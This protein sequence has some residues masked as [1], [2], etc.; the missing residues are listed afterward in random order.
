MKK[1]FDK[2]I[3]SLFADFSAASE[4]NAGNLRKIL[5]DNQSTAY[6]KK[7]G[8][9]DIN[10]AKD[11]VARVPVSNYSNYEEQIC[12]G[13]EFLAYPIKYILGTS[14]TTGK[15]K[16]FPLTKEA[17]VRYSSYIYDMPYFLTHV[18]GKSL[19]TSVFRSPEKITLLSSAY[20]SYLEKSGALDGSDFV[21]GRELLFSDHISDVQYVKARLLLSHPE[22]VSIQ[23]IFVYDVLLILRYLE[24]NWQILID[25]M[26]KKRVSSASLDD[27]IKELMY[28][29]C[30][31][32]NRLSE[33]EE[34]FGRASGFSI[35][36]ILPNLRFISGI[37][38]KTYALQEA[39]LRRYV[40]DTPIYY[41]A[42]A[43][44]ECMMGVAR[45]MDQAEY[46]LLPRSAYYE[47][48]PLDGTK[49]VQLDEISVGESY[50]PV[51]TTFS[52]LYRYQT[53][54]II[55]ILSYE[56]E[57]PVFEVVGRRDRLLNVA[58]EKLDEQTLK[59]AVMRLADQSGTR[60][61]DFAIGVD[62][63]GVP[64]GYALF[65]EAE[66]SIDHG[67]VLFDSILRLLSF[68]YDDIRSLG[69]LSLPSVYVLGAGDI[70]RICAQ[71]KEPAHNKPHTFLDAQQVRELINSAKEC[72]T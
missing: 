30:A 60:I 49:P 23:S 24:S 20:F 10:S 48:L 31:E 34:I 32:E 61:F 37:G 56:G 68:D 44:S 47:F 29:H 1:S 51:I 38:G 5:A 66:R 54:D 41:F 45:G 35:T 28:R 62:D 19:H 9:S 63:R 6:G 71:V 18:E 42:Y 46:V 50:E 69:M 55:K 70:S 36:D 11:Y 53:G 17:L 58:G 15:Q 65:L 27:R 33:L 7:C 16:H 67:A 4:I 14:G 22:I 52:G 40:G 13:D 8:F 57:S 59:D 39:A 12:R 2:K 21:G 25:D 64:F 72:K 26:R 43:S 3:E